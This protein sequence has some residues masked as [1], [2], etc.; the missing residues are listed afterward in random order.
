MKKI[1]FLCLLGLSFLAS[2][3]ACDKTL[4]PT[5]TQEDAG[6]KAS[7]IPSGQTITVSTTPSATLTATPVG[8]ILATPVVDATGNTPASQDIQE[9]N[10]E[11]HKKYESAASKRSLGKLSPNDTTVSGCHFILSSAPGGVGNMAGD[12]CIVIQFAGSTVGSG[13]DVPVAPI[14]FG[15]GP[16]DQ[17]T[18][19]AWDVFCCGCGWTP[20]YLT[21]A[22]TGVSVQLDPGLFCNPTLTTCQPSLG[23]C[24]SVDSPHTVLSVAVK[25]IVD[26]NGLSVCP[27]ASPS[28]TPTDTPTFTKTPMT[29]TPTF[30]P[31]PVPTCPDS[32]YSL[33]LTHYEQDH[34]SSWD[35]TELDHSTNSLETI[36][37]RGC[38]LCCFAMLA[39]TPP[40]Q[41]NRL[42][43]S[44]NPPAI[45]S[46]GTLY[47]DNAAQVLGWEFIRGS[48]DQISEAL[49]AGDYVIAHVPSSDEA[50]HFVVITGVKY[51]PMEKQ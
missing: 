12:D 27:E 22:D 49:A 3:V 43:A 39:G 6:V 16:D 46:A 31:S 4:A 5:G 47:S 44:A 40:D 23:I 50:G 28:P 24:G 8:T 14:T 10:D 2:V 19:L 29:I 32:N 30:T 34:G 48:A 41:L 37:K 38:L 36:G 17:L 11:L 7:G 45:D 1:F 25:N 15:G 42:L 13:C 18:I 26:S 35:F 51:D 9:A 21:N 20:F 33:S